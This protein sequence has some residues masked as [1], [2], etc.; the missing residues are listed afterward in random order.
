VY[1]ASELNENVYISNIVS[2]LYAKYDFNEHL[3]FKISFGG[4]LN[5]VR[6]HQFVPKSVHWPPTEGQTGQ[7]YSYHSQSLNWLNENALNYT[8]KIDNHDFSILLGYTQ[9]AYSIDR[10]D[11]STRNFADNNIQT[12]S[13]G[14]QINTVSQRIEE[15][16]LVS[17]L[18][19]LSYNFK[20]K[21][22]M[23]V[24]T[25]AD[26]SSRFGS[27]TKF[28]YF[29]SA[30]FGWRFTEEEFLSERKI[31]DDGKLRI[32]YGVSG[33]NSIG[34]YSQ[35]TLLSNT[36]YVLG[37]NQTTVTGLAPGNIGNDELG[38]ETVEMINFGTDL[39]LLNNRLKLTGEYYFKNTRNLLLSVP[40][41]SVTGF[42]IAISNSGVIKNWG[43]EFILSSKNIDKAFKWTTDIN[44]SSNKN[45]IISLGGAGSNG[46][47]LIAP[48]IYGVGDILYNEEGKPFSQFYGWVTDGIFQTEEE[49]LQSLGSQP[50]ARPGDYKFVDINKDG[51]IDPDDRTIIGSAL[52]DLIYGLNNQISYKNFELSIFLQGVYGGDIF[53]VNKQALATL[54]G[55]ANQLKAAVNR[56]RSPE[57]PG[58]GFYSRANY[59]DY[60]M[61][62]RFSD[63]WIEDG[64]YLRVKNL[65]FAYNFSPKLL[66]HLGLKS[67]RLYVQGNNLFTITNY[68]GFDPEVSFSNGDPL[69]QGL[70]WSVYPISKTYT[71]GVN[72]SF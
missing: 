31:I 57:N 44:L 37:A 10:M 60:N 7:A 55:T 1:I 3:N 64:S 12:I 23:N 56:W 42:T 67:T 8:Q 50:A 5:N 18:A 29:P 69:M 63:R 59:N 65:T 47:L 40:I 27:N 38:W 22:L 9:Q 66:R 28:G 17:Y 43:W 24:T 36:R 6:N 39:Y 51:V 20:D 2:N 13:A 45:K 32:S 35:Y 49:V 54:G 52:P 11:A 33:N 58:D 34:N 72:L 41:P 15:W 48:N 68:S 46:V 53:N 4:N 19:R 26:G 21:Y 71:V 62:S 70:D 16:S 61:N 30:S 25:R 14:T